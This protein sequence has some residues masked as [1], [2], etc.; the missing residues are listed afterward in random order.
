MPPTLSNEKRVVR[1]PEPLTLLSF[2]LGLALPQNIPRDQDSLATRYAKVSRSASNFLVI[3]L[4]ICTFT[5]SDALA[6]YEARPFNFPCFPSSADE[7]KAGERFFQCQSTSL[8]FLMN[9]GF[10]FNKWIRHGIP[11]LTRPEEDA[12][13]IR[14][15]EKEALRAASNETSRDIPIDD[16]N[17]SFMTT[18]T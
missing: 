17:R 1:S 5:W 6:G 10:D 14:K 16:R 4:G 12:Y 2:P 7:A 8:E 3:Q 15:T 13:L 11:Y 18:T 9:N